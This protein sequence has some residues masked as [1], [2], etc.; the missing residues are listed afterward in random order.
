MTL[1]EQIA[2]HYGLKV[3]CDQTIEE[4]AE[5]KKSQTLELCLINFKFYSM[6]GK[7]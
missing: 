1:I 3:Q 7:K 6:S 4:M 5:W 2:N